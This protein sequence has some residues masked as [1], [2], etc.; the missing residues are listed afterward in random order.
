MRAFLDAA[1]ASRRTRM[2]VEASRTSA[3]ANVRRGRGVGRWCA[4]SRRV[5]SG[6]FPRQNLHETEKPLSLSMTAF[7]DK[8][9]LE[10]FFVGILTNTLSFSV[11]LRLSLSR[12]VI[13]TTH[14][15]LKQ[16]STF[17]RGET[18]L[19]AGSSVK[20]SSSSRR[21]ASVSVR[22]AGDDERLRLHNLSPLPGS[23]RKPTRKGRGYG[24]GQG[25]TCGYGMRGQKA[26]GGT[27]TRPGFEGGQ[28]PMYRRFPK[29]K[30]IAGG[31]SA[32]K[33]K[34]V[35]VNVSDLA[36]ALADSK[37]S[38]GQ[39]VDL[40]TLKSVGLIKAT[41]YY[42]NLPLKVLGDGELTQGLKVKAAAF[43]ASASEKLAAAG[44]EAIL[45]EGK[46]PKWSREA[47]EA[48]QAAAK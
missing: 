42:R 30:G 27:G 31:M 32:G 22:A 16:A 29:L 18:T 34:F 4:W 10:V 26:R 23:R 28:T 20:S 15:T 2:S 33:P 5:L 11:S 6:H 21:H 8:I 36:Q 46:K 12:G 38:A 1:R 43:S 44:G 19:K 7:L 41:G 17:I 14:D 47:H 37:I 3:K 25:G 48:A 45:V 40:D 13:Y 9:E 35:T 39:D 24:A